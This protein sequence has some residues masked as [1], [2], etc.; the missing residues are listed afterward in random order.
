MPL[1]R[2]AAVVLRLHGVCWLFREELFDSRECEAARGADSLLPVA[3]G[4][5]REFPFF[6]CLAL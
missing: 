5:E 3:E 2:A 1:R 4:S 6:R